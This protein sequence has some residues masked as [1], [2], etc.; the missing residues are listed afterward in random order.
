[1]NQDLRGKKLARNHVTWHGR[2]I[3]ILILRKQIICIELAHDQASGQFGYYTV[4]L[5]PH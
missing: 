4:M 2:E 1:M 3:L 5:R